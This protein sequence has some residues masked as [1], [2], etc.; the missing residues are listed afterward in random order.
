MT[1]RLI[2]TTRIEAEKFAIAWS[3]FSKTGYTLG[4]GFENVSVDIYDITDKKKDWIDNYVLK[5][6]ELA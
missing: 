5:I 4:S 2:F 6:N 1:S 3:R